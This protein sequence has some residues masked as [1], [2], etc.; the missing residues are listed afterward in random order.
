MLLSELSMIPKGGN[1]GEL[2]SAIWGDGLGG[3]Q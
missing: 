1:H 3:P 2:Y